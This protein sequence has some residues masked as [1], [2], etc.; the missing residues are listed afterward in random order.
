MF[1]LQ[2]A[3]CATEM[4]IMCL[5]CF[6]FAFDWIRLFM[7]QG[8]YCISEIQSHLL[9]NERVHCITRHH[10]LCKNRIEEKERKWCKI[11]K[12]RVSHN[13]C[14]HRHTD[15]RIKSRTVWKWKRQQREIEIG[16]KHY[17]VPL[18]NDADFDRL[19]CVCVWETQSVV[20]IELQPSKDV[21]VSAPPVRHFLGRIYGFVCPQNQFVTGLDQH[22]SWLIFLSCVWPNEIPNRKSNQV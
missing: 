2:I 9:Q 1:T 4:R 17:S 6:V 11:G 22:G 15:E 3:V 8:E 13:V 21:V 7:T 20:T 14:T 19:G 16:R 10:H 5:F 12:R 18:L